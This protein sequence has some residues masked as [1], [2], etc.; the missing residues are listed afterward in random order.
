MERIHD[1]AADELTTDE[2]RRRIEAWYW[3]P[4]LKLGS[5]AFNFFVPHMIQ[6][7][8]E[9]G[10]DRGIS[11]TEALDLASPEQID[12]L[13]KQYLLAQIVS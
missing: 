10:P 12:R 7:I 8:A 11:A 6:L 5:D 1:Q 9:L 3:H 4:D 2:K 13:W